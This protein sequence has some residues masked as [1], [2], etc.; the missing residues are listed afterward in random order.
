MT[1]AIV[2]GGGFFG[3]SIAYH[4]KTARGFGEVTLIE[5]EPAAMTRAS[6]VNQARVHGGYHYLRSFTT[7]YRSR[8]NLAKFC[9]EFSSAVATPYQSIYALAA[10][11][12]KVT[13]RQ[14]ERFCEAIGAP[15]DPVPQDLWQYFDRRLI[16]DAWLTEEKVFDAGILHGIMVGRLAAAGVEVHYGT[17]AVTIDAGID[18][19]QVEVTAHGERAMLSADIVF[20][21]T[22]SNLQHMAGAQAPDF[23]LCHEIAEIVLV[24]PPPPLASLGI[25]VMDGPF[26][27]MI[28]FP[29]RG[30]H[31]LTHVRYTPHRAWPDAPGEDPD[32]QLQAYA[33]GS[34][35]D[36]MVRDASRYVPLIAE[37]RP[38]ET[39]FEV[40]TILQRNAGDDGRP[41]LFERHGSHGRLVS[42][43][44]GKLDNIYD[45]LH[46]IDQ[47]S[48]HFEGSPT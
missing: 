7:A 31:S 2:V 16:S 37:C 18:A 47:E 43:L 35:V 3:T 15:L 46:R 20:N 45:A 28:P 26:F 40:K 30:L 23:H 6:Y 1:S 22:Y 14:V 10:R 38:A 42:V 4:L 24:E 12:S 36:W 9:A 25:T 13:P 17:E 5:R 21:C 39:L 32:R 44:G 29:S 48:F 34:S 33:G 11:Q 27:S 19:A 41:I 8:V